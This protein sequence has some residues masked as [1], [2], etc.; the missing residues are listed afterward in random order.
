M[1]GKKAWVSRVDILG[2]RTGNQPAGKHLT[3]ALKA[4]DSGVFQL[5]PDSGPQQPF[6]T[7]GSTKYPGGHPK[8]G[9]RVRVWYRAEGKKNWASSV[10]RL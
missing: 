8:V 4:W 9:Q 5:L 10:E 6:F 1:E 2:K 7:K 3:G